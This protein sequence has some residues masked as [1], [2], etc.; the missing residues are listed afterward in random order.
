[1]IVTSLSLFMS[2]V[3]VTEYAE[4]VVPNAPRKRVANDLYLYM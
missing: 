2:F 1:M 3:M 4:I